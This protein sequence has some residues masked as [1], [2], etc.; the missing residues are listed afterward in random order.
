MSD[1]ETAAA[2]GKSTWFCVVHPKLAT[3]VYF[4]GEPASIGMNEASVNAI[5]E[6]TLYITPQGAPIRA[7]KPTVAT[8]TNVGV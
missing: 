3:A 4:V 7:D 1:Y 5:A 6:T 2:A 8:G